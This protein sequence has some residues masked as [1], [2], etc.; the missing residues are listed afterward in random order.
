MQTLKQ[1]PLLA[2]FLSAAPPRVPNSAPNSLLLNNF[3]VTTFTIKQFL[4]EL[5]NSLII[6]AL[7]IGGRGTNPYYFPFRERL[8]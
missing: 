3:L 5:A 4:Y 2:A 6:S 1:R 7:R 8:D